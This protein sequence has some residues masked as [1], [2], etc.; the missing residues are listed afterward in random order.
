MASDR[1]NILKN[2]RVGVRETLNRYPRT[3]MVMIAIALL[4]A[5]YFLWSAMGGST[6]GRS[7]TQAYF[8]IDDGKTWFVDDGKK[9]P[10]FQKG[11][12]DAVRA[13]VYRCPDGTKFVS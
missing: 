6:A 9:I 4:A 5:V 1:S 2:P 7:G 10:P 12:K 3:T 8:S 11:G 13:Y